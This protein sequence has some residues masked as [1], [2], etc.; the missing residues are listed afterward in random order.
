MPFATPLQ[1]LLFYWSHWCNDN[2]LSSHWS[3]SEP[4][5]HH[6][7]W[8]EGRSRLRFRSE[9]RFVASVQS[10][11]NVN[12]INLTQIDWQ[13]CYESKCRQSTCFCVPLKFSNVVAFPRLD[14]RFTILSTGELLIRNSSKLDVGSYKCQTRHQLTHE[15]VTSSVSGQLIVT[16]ETLIIS[17]FHKQYLLFKRIDSRHELKQS[18]PNTSAAF[19]N[20]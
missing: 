14:S 12:R 9:T 15:M 19:S 2:S 1:L 3:P 6:Y 16:G 4:Y 13:L 8:P 18:V 20:A 5:L 11:A 7:T 10:V 17:A